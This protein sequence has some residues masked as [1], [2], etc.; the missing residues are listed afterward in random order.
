[1][2]T[3]GKAKHSM[4]PGVWLILAHFACFLNY[5]NLVTLIIIDM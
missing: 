1:M 4:I 3:D 2:Q 5:S